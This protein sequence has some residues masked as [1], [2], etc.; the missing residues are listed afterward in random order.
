MNTLT[1]HVCL[2]GEFPKESQLL[3]QKWMYPI[4]NKVN[5]NP[6]SLNQPLSGIFTVREGEDPIAFVAVN[7][8]PGGYE[9]GELCHK[10]GLSKRK[11]SLA[12]WR[13]FES[14]LETMRATK[15]HTCTVNVNC[16]DEAKALMR[17]GWQ[18]LAYTEETNTYR[19]RFS[20]PSGGVN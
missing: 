3:F 18:K 20:L 10:E 8:V 13:I 7:P 15:A 1:A 6:E 14:L 16:S 12:L 4:R 17:R 9:L 2:V 11:V 5:F 19:L